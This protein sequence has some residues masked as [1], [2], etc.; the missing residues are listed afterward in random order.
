MKI[1]TT[2]FE[3]FG[4]DTVNA[5][6]EAVRLLP[7]QFGQAQIRT[8]CLPV[9]FGRAGEEVEKEIRSWQP[10]LVVCVGVAGGRNRI[11]PERR[12]R[13]VRVSRIPDNAGQVFDGEPIDPNGP[14]ER[15]TRLPLEKAVK[16]MRLAAEAEISEDAG[17]YVCNDLYWAVLSLEEACH[18][19]SLFVHVPPVAVIPPETAMRALLYMLEALQA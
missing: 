17:K 15:L 2:G 7:E 13:N 12:A 16:A 19:R 9:V 14:E 5:S 18:F 1:L 11:T 6:W 10:D 4:G 8:K 3:P